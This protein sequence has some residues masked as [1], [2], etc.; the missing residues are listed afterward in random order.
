MKRHYLGEFEELVMLIVGVLADKAY[1]INIVEE[2]AQRFDRQV[3][4]SA[5]HVTL[6][7][8]EDKGYLESNLGEATPIRGGRRRRVY[9]I[10][11]VGR[12]ELESSQIKRA[13]LWQLITKAGKS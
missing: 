10:T 12:A 5:V 2:I 13:E 11:A 8:L 7:R 9:N 4:L 3:S 6:Y 1:G